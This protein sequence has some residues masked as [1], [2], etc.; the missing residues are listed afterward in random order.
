MLPIKFRFILPSGV[1]GEVFR[2]GPTRNNN[3]LWRP[4]LLTDRDDM[5]NLYRRSSIDAS[6]QMSV[7]LSKRF[8]EEDCSKSTNQKQEWPVVAMFIN[9]WEL[10]TF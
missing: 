6:Y 4:C 3:S 2:N 1:K 7:H 8:R 10:N 9:G 5:T